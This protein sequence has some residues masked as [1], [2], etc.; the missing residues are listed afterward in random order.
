MLLDSDKED[1]SDEED[2]DDEGTE[3]MCRTY[4]AIIGM[5]Q[6]AK[7]QTMRKR[8]YFSKN[9]EIRTAK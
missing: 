1:I 7:S 4:L 8:M 9:T 5:M 3:D 6:K 2:D